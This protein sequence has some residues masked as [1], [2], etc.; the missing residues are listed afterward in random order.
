M[1]VYLPD[2]LYRPNLGLHVGAIGLGSLV[3]EDH[4]VGCEWR[5]VVE[6]DVL[7]QVEAPYGR[8]GLLP[9]SREQRDELQLL[10]ATHQRLEHVGRDTELQRLVERVRIHRDRVALIGKAVGRRRRACCGQSAGDHR[11]RQSSVE[12]FHCCVPPRFMHVR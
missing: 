12:T 9:G 2:L 11:Q 1:V 3:G 4:I 6:L 5:A 8:R 10:A 7:P